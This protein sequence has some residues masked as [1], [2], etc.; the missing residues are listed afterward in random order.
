MSSKAKIYLYKEGNEC[1]SLTGGWKTLNA[2]VT[3]SDN[4]LTVKT[5]STTSRA[6]VSITNK[7]DFN[8]YKKL[9]FY[10]VVH[11]HTIE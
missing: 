1:V 9:I 8:T 11:E 3:N 7:I 10:P 4:V 2:T 5:S 6:C